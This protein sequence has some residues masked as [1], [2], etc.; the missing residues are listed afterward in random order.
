[1]ANKE[2]LVCLHRHLEQEQEQEQAL[3]RFF[4]VEANRP[5]RPVYGQLEYGL[6]GPQNMSQRSWA[7]S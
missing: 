4:K 3:A 2:E 5:A 7:G 6:G 1:M